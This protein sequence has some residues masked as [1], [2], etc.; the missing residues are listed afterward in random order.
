V[1]LPYGNGRFSM[2]LTLPDHGRTL[3]DFFGVLTPERWE[4]WVRAMRREEVA[5]VL[6]RFRM[7]W[8]ASLVK[9][10]TALGMGTAF[11]AG[12][13]DFSEMSPAGR[14][15][16]ISDVRQK[17]FVEVNEEGTEAA[18]V[19]VVEMARVCA[20]CGPSHPVLRFDR[21]FFFAI[22]DNATGT[23]LFLGQVMDPT[24]G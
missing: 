15:L 12:Q 11:V 24:A 10:L 3:T 21:P 20:G 1:A 19:T 22:R 16:F 7:E 18:A 8:E 14:R 17:S 23:V 13:A 9:S 4:G 5:V 2:V 6:P